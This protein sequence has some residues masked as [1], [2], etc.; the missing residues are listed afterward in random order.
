MIYKN[1]LIL[2]K[3][4]QMYKK[5]CHPSISKTYKLDKF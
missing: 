1:Y 2:K 4:L 5:L 3:Q